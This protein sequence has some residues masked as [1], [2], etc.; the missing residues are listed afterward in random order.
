MQGQL[1]AVHRTLA[2]L[3]WLD[4]LGMLDSPVAGQAFGYLL[5][6]QRDDGG[7]DEDPAVTQ[8]SLPRWLTPGHPGTRLYL[9]SHSAYWLGVAGRQTHPAFQKALDFLL[10]HQDETGRFYGFLHSTWI[11]ASVLFMA[12]DR[13]AGAANNGLQVLMGRQLSRWAD[14]DLLGP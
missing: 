14:S 3:N 8:Y 12:G 4:E 5:A 11:A 1:S 13:Y 6:V 7:W 10:K 9:S 2:A